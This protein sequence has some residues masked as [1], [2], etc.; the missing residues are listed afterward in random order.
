MDLGNVKFPPMA[1]WTPA[2]RPSSC[3]TTLCL[4]TEIVNDIVEVAV[5]ISHVG[6]LNV[7]L[8]SFKWEVT[9][10]SMNSQRESER[11]MPENSVVNT[12]ESSSSGISSAKGTL[13]L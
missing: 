1:D 8:K 3:F 5:S 4:L 9:L 2:A 10:V 6:V 12:F 7:V 11:V 13:W